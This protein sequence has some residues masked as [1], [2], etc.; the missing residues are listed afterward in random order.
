MICGAHL[1]AFFTNDWFGVTDYE[2]HGDHTKACFL[3]YCDTKEEIIP[4]L[5]SLSFR[6]TCEHRILGTDPGKDLLKLANWLRSP[7]WYQDQPA[8][9]WISIPMLALGIQLLLLGS[10]IPAISFSE[11]F[12]LLSSIL[13]PLGGFFLGLSRA[14]KK[15]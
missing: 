2:Q 6:E 9:F 11:D 13:I 5:V 12:K 8:V 4:S 1:T 15:P 10:L 7:P 14:I 3:D